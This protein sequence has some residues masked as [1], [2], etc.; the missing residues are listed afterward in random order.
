M[1][2]GLFGGTF[3]PLHNGHIE[4]ITHVKNAFGLDRVDLIPSAV[5]PHKTLKS[6]APARE[7]LQ[8]IEKSV[9]RLPGI[10]A[11]DLEMHRSGPSFTIDTVRQFISASAVD[12]KHYF[13]MGTDAFFEMDTWKNPREIFKLIS[14][15]IMKRGGDHRRL[16]DVAHFL[17]SRFSGT[18]RIATSDMTIHIQE[19]KPIYICPTPAVNISSTVIRQRVKT[20]LPISSLVPKSVEEIIIKKGLYL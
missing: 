1:K 12:T 11:S 17:S 15:I 2:R 16:T 19:L 4:V 5:P 14:V 10:F 6:L 7:R 8:M 13:I 3:N 9:A 18:H 20:Q